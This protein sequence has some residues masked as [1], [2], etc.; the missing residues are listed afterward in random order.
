MKKIIITFMIMTMTLSSAHALK[1]CQL[2]WLGAWRTKPSSETLQ[3]SRRAFSRNYDSTPDSGTWSVTSDESSTDVYHTVTGM[4]FCSST[5]SGT[6]TDGSPSYD[7]STVSNNTNC[8]CRMTS[9]NLGGS[10]VFLDVYGSA[11]SCASNCAILCANH[12]A[13]N[14]AYC[15]PYGTNASC[16]RAAV[17]SLP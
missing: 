3:N 17:L 13:A 7:T 14:C 4:S 6:Y 12:C 16:S 9:P 1:L 15:V 5:N 8:W 10:W 11:S 2:E